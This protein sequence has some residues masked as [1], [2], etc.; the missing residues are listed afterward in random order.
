M[1]K[2]IYQNLDD[3]VTINT[4]NIKMALRRLRKLTE[5]DCKMSSTWITQ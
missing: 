2:R 3:Q 4:R 5:K 1:G